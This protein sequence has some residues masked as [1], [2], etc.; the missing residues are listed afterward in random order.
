M[1]N[2]GL[3][4]PKPD[5]LQSVP[6]ASRYYMSGIGAI[7]SDTKGLTQPPRPETAWRQCHQL[8]SKTENISASFVTNKRL[9]KTFTFVANRNSTRR[10]LES[11]WT[12][13]YIK[14]IYNKFLWSRGREFPFPTNLFI[15][16]SMIHLCHYTCQHFIRK[17]LQVTKSI[18][19]FHSANGLLVSSQERLMGNSS[20][21]TLH[22]APM[23]GSRLRW[24]QIY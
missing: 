4:R 7:P 18:Y 1:S 14:L 9:L 6:S 19:S 22:R 24:S 16:I 23:Q 2:I 17:I 3:S 21:R 10:H 8:W 20:S 15:N 13:K 5:F 11:I 12:C